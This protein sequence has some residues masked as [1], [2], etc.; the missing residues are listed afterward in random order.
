MNAHAFTFILFLCFDFIS[1]SE[2]QEKPQLPYNDWGA[3]PFECCTYREW[4]AES[5]IVVFKKRNEKSDVVFRLENGEA[6]QAVTGVVVTYQLGV[7]KIVKPIEIG[8][9]PGGQKPMLSLKPDDVVYTLHYAGEGDDVFWYKG[10][11]YRDQIAVP[12]NGWGDVPNSESV[13][14][15]SRPKNVW[16]VKVR[17]KA[18]KTG[19]TRKTDKFGNQ[20]ACG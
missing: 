13:K 12:D 4:V 17:N 16:W 8:Y 1:T 14:V 3:C 15:L 19:W 11:S 6:V 20:D 2:A 7:T 9:L 5:P 10:K 18:G